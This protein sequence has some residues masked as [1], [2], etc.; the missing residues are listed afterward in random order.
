MNRPR[1]SDDVR[2]YLVRGRRGMP[3][4]PCTVETKTSAGSYRSR[5]R[6][7][8][9]PTSDC[10][11]V[12]LRSSRLCGIELSI[13]FFDAAG[14]LVPGNRGADMV[15]ASALACSGDLLLR[16]AGCQGKNPIVETRRVAAATS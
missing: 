10:C 3:Y 1:R 13:A 6:L 2:R 15:R 16:L 5:P 8:V 9:V 7:L 11:D 14:P 4:P 12:L